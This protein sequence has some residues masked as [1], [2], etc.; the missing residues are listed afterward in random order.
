MKRVVTFQE[1]DAS[2]QDIKLS[3][4]AQA[5][6]I[7]ERSPKKQKHNNYYKH[8]DK[9]NKADR[10]HIKAKRKEMLDFRKQLPIYSGRDAIMKAIQD[11]PAVIV[12]GET[13]SGK[14]THLL[15]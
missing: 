8:N 6:T 13:G 12:M 4:F 10:A 11:N 2:A 14:T 7:T 1:N 3:D 9:S 15:L 5:S